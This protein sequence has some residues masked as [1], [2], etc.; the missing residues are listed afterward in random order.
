MTRD[1]EQRSPPPSSSYVVTV[2]LDRKTEG[3][4]DGGL[5]SR[6]DILLLDLINTRVYR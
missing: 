2:V 4:E 6:R 1:P 5:Y 3:D